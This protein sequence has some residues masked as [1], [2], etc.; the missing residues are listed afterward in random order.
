VDVVFD[1]QSTDPENAAQRALVVLKP[2]LACF[3]DALGHEL[4]NGFVA[5]QGMA[6]LLLEQADRL[7]DEGREQLNALAQTARRTDEMVRALAD[8][9]RLVRDP[10]PAVALDLGELALEALAEVKVLFPGRA[11]EY[12]L[13][14]R[15][16]APTMPERPWRQFFSLLFRYLV[17]STG[18]GRPCRMV[19]EG[20]VLDH[21]RIEVSATDLTT[22]RTQAEL[23]AMFEP[24]MRKPS[25]PGGVLGLFPLQLIAAGWGGRLCVQAPPT[26]ERG[27]GGTRF[28]IGLCQS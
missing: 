7:N 26:L 1:Y 22:A 8:L 10:G 15:W 17:E 13:A 6:N 23:Q 25:D 18:A 4:P 20:Q 27:Q 12:H 21:S 28:S 14:E 16:P 24:F 5:I 9:G 19:I 3:Q 2:L 11:I